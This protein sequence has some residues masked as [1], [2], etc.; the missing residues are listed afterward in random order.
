LI[1]WKCTHW[2]ARF[3]AGAPLVSFLLL[4]FFF[5]LF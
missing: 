4:F 1:S 3:E 2:L 5:F